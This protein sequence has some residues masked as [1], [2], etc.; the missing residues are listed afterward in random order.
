MEVNANLA[1]DVFTDAG[2]ERHLSHVLAEA[3]EY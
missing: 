1:Q 2:G 3:R